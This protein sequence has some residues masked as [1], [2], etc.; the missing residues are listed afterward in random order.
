LTSCLRSPADLIS[1]QDPAENSMLHSYCL[2]RSSL[3]PGKGVIRGP[4]NGQREKLYFVP[5]TLFRFF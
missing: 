4:G 3:I 1:Y 2:C 5:D